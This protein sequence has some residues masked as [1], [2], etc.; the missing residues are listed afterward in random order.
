MLQGL[1]LRLRMSPFQLKPDNVRTTMVIGYSLCSVIY[2]CDSGSFLFAA[3]VRREK[4]LPAGERQKKRHRL[5]PGFRHLSYRRSICR[6]RFHCQRL[7]SPRK[8]NVLMPR[9]TSS[10]HQI[11]VTHNDHILAGAVRWLRTSSSAQTTTPPLRPA[12]TPPV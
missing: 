8:T 10:A 1:R 6:S 7:I 5:L 9:I 2:Y 3:P 12:I 11:P 4:K